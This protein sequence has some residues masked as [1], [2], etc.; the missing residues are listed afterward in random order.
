MDNEETQRIPSLLS[1]FQTAYF[2]VHDETQIA[3]RHN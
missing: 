3:D 2:I 1:V